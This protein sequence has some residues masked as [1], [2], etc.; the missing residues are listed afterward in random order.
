MIGETLQ[1]ITKKKTLWM[2]F[3]P[4]ARRWGMDRLQ[5]I[6]QKR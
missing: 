5:L 3:F 6:E 4:S 2:V 1:Q